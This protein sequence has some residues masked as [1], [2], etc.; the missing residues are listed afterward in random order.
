MK[1]SGKEVISSV[2]NLIAFIKERVANDLITANSSK[3]IELDKED[4]RKLNYVIGASID[5]SYSQG[6]SELLKVAEKL[7]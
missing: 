3:M 5:K 7:K 4:L 2:S 6:S 1:K